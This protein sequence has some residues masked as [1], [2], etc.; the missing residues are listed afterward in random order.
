MGLQ[1]PFATQKSHFFKDGTAVFNKVRL[2]A[3]LKLLLDAVHFFVDGN[4]V[5]LIFLLDIVHFFVKSKYV[6]MILFGEVLLVL[7]LDEEHFSFD[8][9][10]EAGH[11]SDK[12][13]GK[14]KTK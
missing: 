2:E 14:Y 6:R 12:T 3:L 4:F 11:I 13:R 7:L 9:K 1:T 10:F 8:G 5:F